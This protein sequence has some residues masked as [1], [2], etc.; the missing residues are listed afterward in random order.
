MQETSATLPQRSSLASFNLV[1]WS[2]GAP[3]AR[4]WVH[5]QAGLHSNEIPPLLTAVHLRDRLT[6]LEEE[7]KLTGRVTV[8]PLANPIGLSQ[9]VLG[10]PEGR[11]DLADGTNFNRDF[12]DLYEG[13]RRVLDK[14]DAKHPD[15][16]SVSAALREALDGAP[17]V[18]I[19]A[20][21][22]NLLVAQA[23]GADIV[24]D[25]HSAVT[26]VVHLVTQPAFAGPLQSLARR[27]DAKAILTVEAD[28]P[29]T[30]DEAV[31]LPRSRL[32]SED[33]QGRISPAIAATVELRGNRDVSDELAARDAEAILG[34]CADRGVSAGQHHACEGGGVPVVASDR[35]ISVDAPL[36]GIVVLHSVPGDHV[37]AGDK[38]ADIVDPTS[39]E[40]CTLAAPGDGL[41][42]I[43]KGDHF[44][45]RGANIL[46][47][48]PL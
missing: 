19:T 38:L 18:S 17:T 21:L 8:V 6:R 9:R 47:I 11:Y 41:I 39:G 16:A 3:R 22:R 34:Y 32:Q 4:P 25:L 15:D 48:A 46:Q 5:I 27:L 43:G 36:P 33:P 24:L 28:A 1:T 45:F 13:A 2:F 14:G 10:R 42:L 30:F 29:S 12:P 40:R 20:A 26:G 44:A 23:L 37:R 7:G 31:S 35:L